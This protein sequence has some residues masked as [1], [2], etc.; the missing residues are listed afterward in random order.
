MRVTFTA[1]LRDI[2]KSRRAPDNDENIFMQWWK[3]D[4]SKNDI[5]NE[6]FGS[7]SCTGTA[8]IGKSDN[9]EFLTC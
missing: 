8:E 9:V 5:V 6:T 2:G 7:L 1:K 3:V 4:H